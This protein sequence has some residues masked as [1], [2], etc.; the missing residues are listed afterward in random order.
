MKGLTSRVDFVEIGE[1]RDRFL[2]FV[3]FYDFFVVLTFR[4]FTLIVNS[5]SR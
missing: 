5:Y 1:D 3:V 4:A 2:G